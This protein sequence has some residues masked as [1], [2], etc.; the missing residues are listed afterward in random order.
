MKLLSLRLK[1]LFQ[2]VQLIFFFVFL[3]L[4]IYHQYF[5]QIIRNRNFKVGSRQRLLAPTTQIIIQRFF[6]R[7]S[8]QLQHHELIIFTTKRVNDYVQ[9]WLL[10]KSFSI[11]HI[12][13]FE[14][15]ILLIFFMQHW[16]NLQRFPREINFVSHFC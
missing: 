12:F 3:C 4:K 14:I 6:K 9:P 2:N 15:P 13:F 8:Q 16:Y 1:E 7:L 10:H 11:P 5:V